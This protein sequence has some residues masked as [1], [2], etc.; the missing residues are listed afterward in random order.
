MT[1]SSG[2]TNNSWKDTKPGSNTFTFSSSSDT[3]IFQYQ[4]NN[5][6]WKNLTAA[7]GKAT[8]EWNPTGA[9]VLRVKAIDKATNTSSVTTW[10]FGNG[11]ASLSSP[12]AGQTSSDAFKVTA[13]GPTSSTGV[14]TPKVYWREADAVSADTTLYGATAGWYEAATLPEIAQGEAVKAE[15]MLD[16]ASAPAGKLKELG[17]DRLATL[18]EIQVCFDYAGA[19]A[20]SKLQCTTNKSKKA[21]QATKLPHAFGDNYPTAEAGDGQVALTTGE[22]NFSETDVNVDAGNTDLSVSRSY[23]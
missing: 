3:D 11:A 7:S 19:P 20:A 5:D 15:T 4:T 8:L 23:S 17:K 21:V 12:T 13:Q 1:S 2:Y 22:L 14:V 9:N 6:A 10:T 18:V 16:I